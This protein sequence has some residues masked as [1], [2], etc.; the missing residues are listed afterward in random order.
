MAEFESVIGHYLS[1]SIKQSATCKANFFSANFILKPQLSFLSFSAEAIMGESCCLNHR[2]QS[3]LEGGGSV[4]GQDVTRV[5][6]DE[7]VPNFFC[8]IIVE[9]LYFLPWKG[10]LCLALSLVL[11]SVINGDIT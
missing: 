7:C 5:G 11:K 10:I 3:T 6:H 4:V 9:K 1:K 8:P 2:A